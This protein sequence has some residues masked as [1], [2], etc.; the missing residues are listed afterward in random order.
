MMYRTWCLVVGLLASSTVQLLAA[1]A[2]APYELLQRVPIKGE[3]NYDYLIADADSRRVYVTHG[4]EV[5]ILD[6]DTYAP[7]GTLTGLT[8]AHGIAVV[9]GLPLVFVTNGQGNSLS[10]FDAK[11]LKATAE[12]KLA[13]KNPDALLYDPASKHLFVFDHGSGDV[14]VV[15]PV[16]A[17]LVSTFQVGGELEFGQAD[18]LGTVWVNVEDTHEVVRIDSKTRK[19]TARWSLAPGEGPTGMAFDAKHRRLFIG[20]LNSKLAVVNADTGAVVAILPIGPGV[21]A[22]EFDPQ[23]GDIF[24][25]CGKSGTMVIIHQDSANQY[26]VAET[27]PTQK[28][29]RTLALDPKTHRVFLPVGEFPPSGRGAPAPGTFAVLVFGRAR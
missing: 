8:G 21:D 11:T 2:I 5:A 3:G 6:A 20:C 28:W 17:K 9:P 29:A 23:T 24:C 13:G 22:T 4:S 19:V 18:G 27:V 7:V 26:H 12:I 25:S 16:T 14:E 1:A 15:D 10:V